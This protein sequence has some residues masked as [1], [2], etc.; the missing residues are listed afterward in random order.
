MTKQAHRI[1]VVMTG[2]SLL[3]FS[4]CLTT[5]AQA[6]GEPLD[7]SMP[8]PPPLKIV[9]AEER[10]QLAAERDLKKRTQLSLK[11]A[12]ARLSRAEQLT[13]TE[14]FDRAATEL[15]IYQG[16]VDDALK[17]LSTF[18]PE[19]DKTRDNYKRLELALRAHVPRLEAMRRVT[20]SEY[21]D[22]FKTMIE[23][24]RSAREQ[25]LDSF[26]DDTVLRGVGTRPGDKK[27]DAPRKSEDKVGNAQK[28]GSEP[29]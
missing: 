18:A 6:Q 1:Q 7:T 9:P 8:A 20:P 14:E 10:A 21:A 28:T 27:S 11:L 13:G 19:K 26:Y 24:V 3:V 23:Y 17:F 16:L 25:A 5:V 12:A 2:V 15:G 4:W 22:I 29:D